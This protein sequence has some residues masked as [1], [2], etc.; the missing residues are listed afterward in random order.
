MQI[1]LFSLYYL[2]LRL[3]LLLGL[4]ET[5]HPLDLGWRWKYWQKRNAAKRRR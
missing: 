1:I 5:I 2:K 4:H 3:S